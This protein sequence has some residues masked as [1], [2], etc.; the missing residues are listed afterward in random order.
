MGLG[1]CNYKSPSL[2][3]I[4]FDCI[5][6]YC[7]MKSPNHLH[8]RNYK[9]YSFSCLFER[10]FRKFNLN[11]D[12]LTGTID[13]RA[14]FTGTTFGNLKEQKYSVTLAGSIENYSKYN[15]KLDKC[16][17]S[18]GY[19]SVSV[20]NVASSRKEGFGDHKSGG[21]ATGTWVRCSYKIKVI[22][23]ILCIVMHTLL[24]YTRTFR[25]D[26]QNLHSVLQQNI[27]GAIWIL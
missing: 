26:Y 20:Q 10:Y 18:A 13:T 2:H 23:F 21:S 4:F 19:M 7:P 24:I 11:L 17:L 16:E 9:I 5:L 8:A 22:W 3:L 14:S 1:P 12:I 25:T 15:L 6:N 27:H